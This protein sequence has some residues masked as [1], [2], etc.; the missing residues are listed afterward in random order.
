LLLGDQD[1]T[2]RFLI[3][4][5]VAKSEINN[6]KGKQ[7]E[8]ANMFQVLKPVQPEEFDIQMK[9]SK[10]NMSCVM[11]Q[12]YEEQPSPIGIKGDYVIKERQDDFFK[13]VWEEIYK[14]YSKCSP[15][16]ARNP[17]VWAALVHR[18]LN[19]FLL[20]CFMHQHCR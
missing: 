7:K 9:N 11:V 18:F 4:K 19:S 3:I 16:M 8:E 1:K 15:N 13:Q 10:E 5:I 6:L 20:G 14:I 2:P 17:E 12:G